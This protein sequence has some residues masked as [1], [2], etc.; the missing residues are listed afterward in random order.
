MVSGSIDPSAPQKFIPTAYQTIMR[1]ELGTS[2]TSRR[3]A[4]TVQGKSKNFPNSSHTPAY[5]G[6]INDHEAFNTIAAT[7]TNQAMNLNLGQF[8]ANPLIPSATTI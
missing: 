3:T 5:T 7:T 2:K 6:R 8:G 1:N 4:G